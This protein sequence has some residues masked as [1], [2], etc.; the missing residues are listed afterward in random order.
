MSPADGSCRPNVGENRDSRWQR[1]TVGDDGKD[2]QDRSP[3]L[4][5]PEIPSF[6]SKER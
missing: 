6:L 4:T 3:T 1:P 2:D 5:V